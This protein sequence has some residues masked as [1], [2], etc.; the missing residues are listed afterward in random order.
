VD[1]KLV[2]QLVTFPIFTAVIGYITNWTG[3]LMLFAPVR[4]HGFRMPGQAFVYPYLPRRIQVL[5]LFAPDGRLGWQGMVPSRAEKMASIAVD[6]SIAKL[7]NVADF[8]RELDP[9]GI[10]EQIVRV[11]A[12]QVHG[13]V[14]RIANQSSPRLWRSL[15][16]FGKDAVYRFVAAELPAQAQKITDALGE[17]VEDLIDP[18][19]MIIHHLTENPRLLISLFREMGAKELRFMQN[20]GGYFG[21][22]MGF[23]LVGVQRLLPYWWVLP[24]GG[25]IIGYIVNWL[26]ITMIYEPAQPRRWIPW[27]IGLMLKRRPEITDAY[28]EII[29][30]EVIT[31]SNIAHELLE[32]ERSDRTLRVLDGLMRESVDKALGRARLAVKFGLGDEYDRIQNALAPEVMA[33]TGDVLAD[34]E[35]AA[36]QSGKVKEFCAT[37]MRMMSMEEFVDLLRSAT[38]QDEWL[39]FAHGAVLGSIG[40]FV[41]LAIFGV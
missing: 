29:A 13:I 32:G 4:F 24:I 26:G 18:K 11:A 17:H 10:A 38:K 35:F 40:G 34:T 22:L 41:H 28:C 36:R 5:P 2:I 16:Q 25:V 21:F 27:R 20:F 3:I 39:L 31:T 9:D 23:V 33:L 12:P 8:Y 7:G 14:D 30:D 37:Q 15:P 19:W 1:H 6:K